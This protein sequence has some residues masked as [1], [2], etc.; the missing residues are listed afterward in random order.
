MKRRRPRI[1]RRAVHGVLLLDKG[2]GVSSNAAL[3][4]AKRLLSR[5]EG[6]PHRHARSAGHRPAAA[7][8]RRGDEVRAGAASMPT[9]ATWPRCKLGVTTSTGDAE[10]EVVQT[11]AVRRDARRRRA[12]LRRIRRRDP[13]GAADALGPEAEGQAALRLRP[14]RRRHRADAARRHDPRDRRL[15]TAKAI[16]GVSTSR[17]ARA[18]TSAPWPR[19]S[20]RRSVAAPTWRRCAAPAAAVSRSRLRCRSNRW[21]HFDTRALDAA[22]LPARRPRCRLAR[23]VARRR[24]CRPLPGR[25]APPLDRADAPQVRVYGPEAR[26]L[27]SAHIAG[28]E[29]IPT[30]LLSPLKSRRPVRPAAPE[31]KNPKASCHD[32]PDPKHRHHRPRRPRQDD[33]GR[34]AAAPER[35]LPRPREGGRAGDGLERPR[36]GARHHHPGEEL[37]RRVEGHARQH[38]RHPRPRRLRRRGRARA[39]DGRQRAAADRRRRRADAADPLRHQEGAGPGPE[40]DRRRQQGRPAR[41]ARRLRGQRH[42]RSVRQARRHRRAARLPGHL[43]LRAERLGDAGPKGAIGTDLSPLFDAIL[44]HVPAHEGE[45][46]DP[47]QLQICSLDYSTYVGRIGIG[48]INQGTLKPMQDVAAV[49]GPGLDADQGARQPGAEVRR[50]RAPAGDRGRPRRHR[51]HQRHRGHRHRRDADRP[52]APAAAADAE[53]RRADADD[54]LLRQQLARSPAAK[55]SSS[56]AGR[57]A[58]AS[59][60][61]CSRTWR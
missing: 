20:A 5:R 36:E 33:A 49:F 59:T 2:L 38:R 39:V 48:R 32:P 58:T 41:R 35:H 37:R 4:Q 8:L 51:A 34:P 61:S 13:S 44:E 17:A 28:G 7:L 45:P 31:S 29:L 9:S 43:R 18:P 12:C 24:R 52:R 50:P 56:P 16:A 21:R 6:R 10:G 42:L 23:G 60:A 11:R 14:R 26:F 57:S 27:G 54:E 19:T 25:R 53:G 46:D 15:S 30:R 1:V 3:Q 22:L 55:A 40:A 47:L